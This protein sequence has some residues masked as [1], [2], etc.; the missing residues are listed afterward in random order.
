MVLKPGSVAVANEILPLPVIDR[1]GVWDV[2][3]RGG[4]GRNGSPPAKSR[5]ERLIWC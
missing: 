1:N 3:A 5:K 4:R 2:E